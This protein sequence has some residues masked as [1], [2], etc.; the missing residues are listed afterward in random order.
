[1]AVDGHQQLFVKSGFLLL[2]VRPDI[3]FGTV[4]GTRGTCGTD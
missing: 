2:L 1:M 3:Q 4:V